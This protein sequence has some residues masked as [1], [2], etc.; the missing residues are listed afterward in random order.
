MALIIN[1][2][3]KMTM[4]KVMAQVCKLPFQPLLKFILVF[5]SLYYS[6]LTLRSGYTNDIYP[7]TL[8]FSNNGKEKENQLQFTK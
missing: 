5:K 4:G 2:E 8:K 1:S 7:T 6:V 3:L